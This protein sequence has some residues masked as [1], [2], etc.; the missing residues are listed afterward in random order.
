MY[1]LEAYA[2]MNTRA[3]VAGL[4]GELQCSSASYIPV[5]TYVSIHHP[6]GSLSC[7]SL[8]SNGE[9]TV[10]QVLW[11]N[12]GVGRIVRSCAPCFK[13]HCLQGASPVPHHTASVPLAHRAVQVNRQYK[14]V[15]Q[16]AVCMRACTACWPQ[17]YT[18]GVGVDTLTGHC[19][20]GDGES[21][22]FNG[23]RGPVV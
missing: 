12:M 19:T 13:V 17:R 3:Y 14:A 18:F 16:V 11:S 6:P 1:G 8:P 5:S 15:G 23:L 4:Y 10:K 9:T 2:S 20:G 21:C 7:S 22:V